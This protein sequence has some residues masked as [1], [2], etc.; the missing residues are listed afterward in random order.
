M[1]PIRIPTVAGHTSKSLQILAN[2]FSRQYGRPVQCNIHY[3][4]RK[5]E[6]T[7]IIQARHVENF[8]R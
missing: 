8:G 6:Y 3:N 5:D 4:V 7:L 1:F 2:K